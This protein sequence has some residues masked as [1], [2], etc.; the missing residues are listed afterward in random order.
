MTFE[1]RIKK[2]QAVNARYEEIERKCGY[3]SPAQAGPEELF[4]CGMQAVE[5]GLRMEDFDMVAEGFLLLR[6]FRA[7]LIAVKLPV[8]KRAGQ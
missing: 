2:A 5:A 1:D 3:A 7:R 6:D 4:R 8:E